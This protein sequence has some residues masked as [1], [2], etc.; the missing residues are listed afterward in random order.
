ML[1]LKF[2]DEV[3]KE[4]F[5]KNLFYLVLLAKAIGGLILFISLSKSFFKSYSQTG[6][7]FSEGEDGF[8]PYTLFRGLALLFLIS[9]S[10]EILSFFDSICVWIEETVTKGLS[11]STDYFNLAKMPE[12]PVTPPD[13]NESS[14]AQ[15]GRYLLT[16]IE[17]INPM[18]WL[19]GSLSYV[20]EFILNIV[21]F[22]VYAVFLAQ[23][24]FVMGL[25]KMFLPLMI[26]LSIYDKL[27]DYIYNVFKIYARYFLVIIP[28][29]FANVFVNTAYI[30]VMEKVR[31]NVVGQA[32]M[33]VSG[34]TI[35]VFALLLAVVIKFSLY[36]ISMS[37]MK[38]LIK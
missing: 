13:P 37:F 36:K 22:F 19:G 31:G 17:F 35:T 8:S 20:L 23:R 30:G 21:D 33:A 18:N 1:T 6:K 32:G 26:A 24:Y 4:I 27:R 9:L 28:Y 5:S 7:V 2:L 12:V 15:I 38:D 34:I 16:V 25:I 14:W 29:I 3:Y 11:P 10:P